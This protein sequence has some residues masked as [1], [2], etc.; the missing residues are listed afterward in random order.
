MRKWLKQQRIDEKLTMRD[1][2]RRLD[3]PFQFISK[4]E[5]GERRLD[6]IEYVTYCRALMVDPHDGIA[7]IERKE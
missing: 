1:L 5:K 2:A 3:V 7:L 4:V 6:V